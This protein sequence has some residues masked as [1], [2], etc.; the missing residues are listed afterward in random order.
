MV[1]KK[2][3]VRNIEKYLESFEK[4]TV[5]RIGIEIDDKIN[6]SLLSKIGFT[7]DL[8][9]GERVLPSIIG[10][11]TRFNSNGGHILL[12]DQPK[13]TYYIERDWTWEDWG[14][15]EHSKIV[16]IPRKRFVRQ[17][18]EAPSI[19]LELIQ[20]SKKD[21]F[22]VTDSLEYVDNNLN[23]IKHK[24]N[25]LL[26]IFGECQILKEDLSSP[27]I[28]GEIK[29]LNWELLKPGMRSWEN[30]EKDLKPI[31]DTSKK[32]KRKIFEERFKELNSFNP[33]FVAIGKNGYS[34]Y[35]V[36]GFP[37]LN[38]YVLESMFYGNAIYIFEENW[39]KLSQ[40][41]KTQ[42]LFGNLHSDRIIHSSEWKDKIHTVLSTNKQ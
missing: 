16:Y 25:V 39:E 1:I 21:K 38:R 42:V 34:G 41:T 15:N 35:V 8:E 19:E 17:I 14:G 13:E 32:S 12:R 37:N 40:L 10:S 11:K 4:G 33:E 28:R 27:F 36:F 9:V 7:V 6:G 23:L 22:I 24:V 26:E 5:I 31:I 20:N 18:I 30:L 3:S 2:K 29:C